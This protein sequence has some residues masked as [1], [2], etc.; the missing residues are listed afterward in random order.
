MLIL[1]GPYQLQQCGAPP[2]MWRAAFLQAYA[3]LPDW[4]AIYGAHAGS[5]DFRCLFGDDE[6]HFVG[7]AIWPERKGVLRAWTRVVYLPK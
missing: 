3:K 4:E 7:Y 5:V 6:A 2:G 1:L